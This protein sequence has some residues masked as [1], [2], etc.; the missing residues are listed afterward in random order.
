[1]CP[2][3]RAAWQMDGHQIHLWQIR[4]PDPIAS[5]HDLQCPGQG[6]IADGIQG[7]RYQPIDVHELG[8][9]ESSL[10]LEQFYLDLHHEMLQDLVPSELAHKEF[11][12]RGRCH[13]RNHQRQE[14]VDEP[15]VRNHLIA[16]LELL[17]DHKCW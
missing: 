3:Y 14:A 6:E 11:G 12:A 10:E 1:M 4:D 16:H 8:K 13:R 15:D 17:G 7:D 5:F 9:H 2:K